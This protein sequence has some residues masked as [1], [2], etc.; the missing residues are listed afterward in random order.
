MA[1]EPPFSPPRYSGSFASFIPGPKWSPCAQRVF[2]NV[3][4][5]R[6]TQRGPGLR[7][8]CV[9]LCCVFP[10][11]HYFGGRS[12]R[13]GVMRRCAHMPSP[14]FIRSTAERLCCLQRG[15]RAYRDAYAR[16]ANPP[17]VRS[18]PQKVRA[19]PSADL[20]TAGKQRRSMRR[21]RVRG[22]H[23][24]ARRLGGCCC[25]P[26]CVKGCWL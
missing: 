11:L 8:F 2:M 18:A 7:S 5:L 13:A 25:A 24:R 14:F 23:Q 12:G 6:A 15:R 19:K 3:D 1:A 4:S 21:S 10:F 22:R 26:L 20:Q 17:G 16:L 9:R